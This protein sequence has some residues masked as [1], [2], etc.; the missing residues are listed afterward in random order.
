MTVSL[1][2][3]AV[4]FGCELR[5][6][7][8]TPVDSVAALANAHPRAITFLSNAKYRAQVATTKAAAVIIDPKNA[9]VCKVAALVCANPYATYARIAATLHPLPVRPAGVHATAVID[10]QARIDPSAHIGPLCVVASGVTIGARAVIGPQCI[11]EEGVSIADDVHLVARVTLC[12]H[13]EVGA[14]TI[15]HPGAVIGSDGFGFAPDGGGAWLKVPQVG[16]V[17]IG[18]DVDIGANTTVDRGA[19][20]DTVLDDGVKLDNQI[21]IGHNVRIGAHTAVAACVGIAGSVT[22]GK[23]CMIGGAVGISGHLA[24]SDDVAITGLSMVS[25]SIHKPGI[26]SSGLPVSEAREWRRTVGR[27]KRLDIYADR[28]AA[29]ERATGVRAQQEEPKQDESD[30]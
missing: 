21:Q 10:P 14:R 3:L 7:P 4:R 8:D 9:D 26:Y 19:I 30:V 23:R 25:R 27:L 18:A 1:G 29:L 28:L 20:E 11:I 5:G 2:E 6:D 15:I 12:R 17:R 22:I 13:V 24:I 16:T